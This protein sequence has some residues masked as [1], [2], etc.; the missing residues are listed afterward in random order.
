VRLG[1][2]CR[3]LS[4]ASYS[5]DEILTAFGEM[6]L[7]CPHRIREGTARNEETDS[8]LFFVT[9]EKTAEKYSPT[10]MYKDYAVSPEL[11]HWESQSVTS[12]ASPTGQRYINHRQRHSNILLF[13]RRAAKIGSRTAA[14]HVSRIGRL[15]VARTG[16]A[17]RVPVAATALDAGGLF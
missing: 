1:S 2:P 16:T 6:T 8:D 11:F 3:C 5:L 10:T 14:L 15:R 9:L 7:D 12:Q 4:I 17:D 13:V